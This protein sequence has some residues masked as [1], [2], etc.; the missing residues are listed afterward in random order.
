MNNN[1][2]A[3]LN[4]KQIEAVKQT[5]GFVR[6]IAGA[7]SGKTRVL[8]HRYAFLVEKLGIDPANI[9]CMTFTNKAA[10]EMKNRISKLVQIH[11][12]NDLVCTIHG[13]C[14]KFLRKEIYRI[15]YPQNFVIIDEEDSK[16]FA[17]QTMEELGLDRNRTTIRQFLAGINVYKS[18]A[19]YVKDIIIPTAHISEDDLKCPQIRYVNLQ[20]KYYSLDFHDLIQFT[21][22]ILNNYSDA[23]ED[24]QKKLNYIMVDEVQD[25]NYP[26]W[27][28]INILSD[29]NK[30]L[31]IVG[32]PD[33][34]IYEWRGSK[35]ELFI[36][37][38]SDKD[39]ILNENYRSTPNILDVANS[40]IVNN[41]KRIEKDLF[42]QKSSGKIALHFH[43]KSEQEEAEWIAKQIDTLI[44]NGV[45][46][47]QI[48]ILYR[49]SYLSRNIEEQLIRKQI[50]YTI[51]GGI[52]FF[53]RKEIKDCICYLRLVASN[54]DMAFKRIVNVPSRKFG[55]A[56]LENLITL[57]T[58]EK[59]TLFDTLLKHR[60]EK[61]FYN[62]SINS[63]IDMILEAKDLS[64]SMCISELMD[65]LLE[66]S[67]LKE[68]YRLDDDED[69]LEN[70]NELI[71]SI[72]LYETSN[73]EEEIS[74]ETYLQDVA[75]YT[76]A[77]YKKD[78][79]TL[80]LMTIH[81]SKG[82]EFP[83]VFICG[84]TEGVFP[85]QRAIR[86]RKRDGLEEERRLMYVAVTRAER[87]VF[88]TESEGYNYQT[89][90]E[91]VP[92][93]FLFEI[94]DGLT[95]L[96]GDIDQQLIDSAQTF[97]KQIDYEMEG[98][99]IANIGDMVDH[100]IFGFGEI[101]DII[102][103]GTT[104]VVTFDEKEKYMSTEFLES[105][106]VEKTESGNTIF[107]VC[108]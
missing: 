49:A 54:D 83:F 51:W 103:D 21:L 60:Y 79:T 13:F 73:A 38:K 80:K 102:N 15:G 25:C 86:D 97:I 8:A 40:I 2:F 91:K 4:D 30:N 18:G 96:E 12:V 9:L 66:K 72:K 1:L 19:R 36:N 82:L 75:L 35:P 10:Q 63:F 45:D 106:D 108:L 99:T 78:T 55:K 107:T 47:S 52:R 58:I 5:E 90:S 32:D 6:I 39:I 94:K 62:P 61:M 46:N 76:N 89:R 64:L 34:A 59:A 71:N 33:Q 92:S 101:V 98:K 24:W 43:G 88:L 50:N 3:D 57:A 93:R 28:L 37:F 20:K 56:H 104:C 95:E 14:V 44:K 85:S 70:I 68:L 17:Q 67:G 42:T 22:Y 74:L 105:C 16:A 29:Y 23:K 26:D 100:E 48:A 53:E 81:Q 77:D 7:G 87:A 65:N 84:L 31:F 11:N 27:D 69:R 41:T